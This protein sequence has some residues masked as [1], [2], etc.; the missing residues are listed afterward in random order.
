MKKANWLSAV[1]VNA[2]YLLTG[3]Y[4]GLAMLLSGAFVAP[5]SQATLWC[6]TAIIAIVCVLFDVAAD[7]S[8]GRFCSW[9]EETERRARMGRVALY[10]NPSLI[11]AVHVV[12][13]TVVTVIALV[14][15]GVS[16]IDVIFFIIGMA[17]SMLLQL[18][19]DWNANYLFRQP[20]CDA[21]LSYAQ[22]IVLIA[23]IFVYVI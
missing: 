18:P 4:I 19:G 10:D 20:Y 1:A 22:Q 13:A 14:V 11:G 15:L 17:V 9:E 8:R 2:K 16:G 7:R 6:W 5:F 3:A 23:A 12:L 21:L